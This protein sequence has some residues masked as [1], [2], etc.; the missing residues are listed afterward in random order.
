MKE[1]T[2]LAFLS[3][4]VAI[5]IDYRSGMKL[6]KKRE[7]YAFLMFM[8]FMMCLVDGYLTRNIVMYNPRYFL[9]LRFF[10][11]PLEDFLFGFSM[12]TLTIILWEYFKGK[13]RRPIRRRSFN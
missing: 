2:I 10:T 9:G 5:I 12:I 4:V 13:K 6:L 3:V 1:Y 7:Y 11:I 8:F